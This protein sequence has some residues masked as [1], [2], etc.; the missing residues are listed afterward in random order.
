MHKNFYKY[1]FLFFFLLA[2]SFNSKGQIGISEEAFEIINIDTSN[3]YARIPNDQYKPSR[4]RLFDILHTRLEIKPFFEQRKLYGKAFITMK[5]YY[6]AANYLVLDAKGMDIKQVYVLDEAGFIPVKYTYDNLLLNITF[7]RNYS[8]EEQFTLFI[9][10]IANPYELE[11]RNAMPS[12]GRG[13]YFIDP[14]DK[15]PYKPTQLWTQNETESASC[16]FPTFDAPNERFTQD[17]Y[18]T[19]PNKYETLS[20]GLFV[21]TIVNDD[22]TKTVQWKQD[23][24]HAAYL[25]MIAVGNFEVIQ[26][27][28]GPLNVN[29][30]TEPQY[31][32]WA[33]NVFGNTPY[34]MSFFSNLLKIDFPWEKYYQ[35]VVRDFTSGAMEN[36]TASVYYQRL[37]ADNNHLADANY[38]DII[39]HELFHHWFGDLVTCESWA[40]LALNESLATYSEYLWLEN[41]YG[42]EEADYH[43]YKDLKSYLREFKY[44]SEPIINF[45]YDDAEELFDAH[46]YQ[47]GGLVM[48]M[49]RDYLGDKVFFDGLHHYLKKHKFSSVEIHDL[50]MA[51]EEITGE[52][53][54]WFFNQWFLSSGHPILKI[55][56]KYFSNEVHLTIEQVQNLEEAPIF[57]FPLTIDLHTSKGIVKKEVFISNKK[58]ILKIKTPSKP[59]FVNIDS[60]KKLLC[61]IIYDRNE[62]Q[63]NIQYS[64]AKTFKDKIEA[65]NTAVELQSDALLLR[66]MNDNFWYIR[67]KAIEHFDLLRA[68]DQEEI[69]N[70]LK[71]SATADPKPQVRKEALRKLG[72][73]NLKSNK[74]LV[75]K[76]IEEDS[77]YIVTAMAYK[78]LYDIDPIKGFQTIKKINH[79]RSSALNNVIAET[80][81]EQGGKFDNEVFKKLLWNSW[82]RDF[83]IV[84]EFYAKFLE[85]MDESTLKN[86]LDFIRS[87]YLNETEYNYRNACEDILYRLL[88]AFEDQNDNLKK[89]MVNKVL[90]EIMDQ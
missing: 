23:L 51:L 73:Y 35:I 59:S 42:K 14:K 47:K 41:K 83:D 88:G 65:L 31:A 24:P 29:Y 44:K 34:M 19:I 36:T 81:A 18:I 90:D 62:K 60:R 84:S 63:A 69:I 72:N 82:G 86:G 10:Y 79:Y 40:N 80:Y 9:E 1:F 64:K 66:M 45:Y 17:I 38:D 28:W 53:L 54:N 11:K 26:D 12:S 2:F 20:N 57:Q 61:E 30:F 67:K 49:L 85:R 46:R 87:I 3:V 50:R 5:P 37:L 22:G 74:A 43:L 77:S 6:L 4:K 75:E 58:T 48:H 8:P 56:E 33:K 13:L 7:S 15:N 76:I 68:D 32:K 21:E 39:A 25:T 52:D 89:E 71:K 78:F 27:H 70:T 16:W 55:K